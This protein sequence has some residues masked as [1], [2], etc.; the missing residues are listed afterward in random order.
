MLV[1]AAVPLA[2]TLSNPSADVDSSIG[3]ARTMYVPEGVDKNKNR[4]EDLLE[5]EIE[6]KIAE[7]NGS[8]LVDV[9]VLLDAIPS[10]CVHRVYWSLSDC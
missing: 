5:D 7:G 8:Q 2:V 9:V 4:I 10:S 1:G 6:Q 3:F